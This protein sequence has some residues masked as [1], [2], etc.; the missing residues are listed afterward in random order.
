MPSLI[1][2]TLAVR[3][4]GSAVSALFV[5]GERQEHNDILCPSAPVARAVAARLVWWS[6]RLNTFTHSPW[7]SLRELHAHVD[8]E[9]ECALRVA[10]RRLGRR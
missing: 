1:S 9:L 4:R 6:E 8:H 5:A 2:S 3:T 7:R 10:R